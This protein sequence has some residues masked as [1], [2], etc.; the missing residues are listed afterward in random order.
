MKTIVIESNRHDAHDEMTSWY[1]IPDSA[2]ANAG[3]PFFIPDFADCFEAHV[4]PVLRISRLGKSI[5]ARFAGRYCTEMAPAVHF[6]APRLRDAL[7]AAHHAPD[8]A[9]SFDRSLI[10]GAF[11]EIED[12]DLIPEITMLANGKTAACWSR[13]QLRIPP[14]QTIEMVSANNTLK[15]GDFIIPAL[16]SP[17]AIKIGDRLEIACGTESLLWIAIR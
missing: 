7:L 13:D 5:G 3:K 16:S 11:R 12:P 17:V 9:C 10:V 14:S 15:T 1:F 4:A 6:R 8:M 2:L